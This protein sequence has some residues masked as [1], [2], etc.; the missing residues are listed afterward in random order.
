VSGVIPTFRIPSLLWDLELAALPRPAD[1]AAA[2]DL[3]WG[4]V[5]TV[6]AT[7][8][9][10]DQLTYALTFAGYELI[11]VAFHPGSLGDGAY[12]DIVDVV[13]GRY[14]VSTEGW[15][16]A[17][18][19]PLPTGGDAAVVFD[20][21]PRQRYEGAG[22]LFAEPLAAL[23]AGVPSTSLGSGWS[24]SSS[25]IHDTNILEKLQLTVRP[26]AGAT[27]D[28]LLDHIE[29]AG[30]T[31]TALV[32]TALGSIP[33]WQSRPP[34]DP[35]GLLQIF[36][37]PEWVYSVP[38]I[39][40]A[41]RQAI[42]SAG[43]ELWKAISADDPV[44]TADVV[45]HELIVNRSLGRTLAWTRKIPWAPPLGRQLEDALGARYA[46]ARSLHRRPDPHPFTGSRRQPYGRVLMAAHMLGIVDVL[47][48][49]HLVDHE[50][51][52]DVTGR[53]ETRY[54]GYDSTD[55]L[56]MR[57]LPNAHQIECI[58][59]NH[60]GSR[61]SGYWQSRHHDVASG[62]TPVT[63]W[64]FIAT[65]TGN[66]ASRTYEFQRWVDGQAG[67]PETG[68]FV[69]STAADA[70][71]DLTVEV[72][73]PQPPF[74][75]VTDY[76]RV[77]AAPHPSDAALSTLDDDEEFATVRALERFPAHHIEELIVADATTRL[78]DDVKGFLALSQGSMK[79]TRAREANQRFEE[80]IGRFLV[81]TPFDAPLVPLRRMALRELMAE[82]HN[83]GNETRTMFDW[84][85][86]MVFQELAETAAIQRFLGLLVLDDSLVQQQPMRYEWAVSLRG[87]SCDGWA[88]AGGFAGTFDITKRESPTGPV[89]WTQQYIV[90]AGTYSFGLSWGC[91]FRFE[92]SGLLDSFSDWSQET[93]EGG[94]MIDGVSSGAAFPHEDEE[95]DADGD[96]EPDTSFEGWTYGPAM[97]TFKGSHVFQ[98]L[99][100]DAS[101]WTKIEGLYFGA[102]A[103]TL[104]GRLMRSSAEP[105]QL[106]PTPEDLAALLA[107]RVVAESDEPFVQLFGVNSSTIRTEALPALELTC[108]DHLA[109]FATPWS[110]LRIVGHASTT[111]DD[112][113]MPLSRARALAVYTKIA[114]T[115]GPNLRIHE[116]ATDIGGQGEFEARHS[117]P[118]N[119]EVPG[120]RRV[121][122][123]L[124]GE[125]MIG[126]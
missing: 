25:A 6:S 76:E 111:G 29:T 57:H 114:E 75:P 73:G 47:G 97:I 63:Q 12:L 74:P 34:S 118:D 50:N 3:L 33:A 24:F 28:D 49:E 11:G 108:A 82:Q 70:D 85:T 7:L 86:D 92:T 81:D 5:S 79:R 9:A 119:T 106:Y 109:A 123:Q 115:L 40:D 43:A 61:L 30:S 102:E 121:D 104:Q 42:D 126:F 4:D 48:S 38:W 41:D 37:Q 83:A 95:H 91:N 60:A 120:W 68:R 117:I 101:G 69:F 105:T 53:Y 36:A 64:R 16:D 51:F 21:E 103:S 23:A 99:Q 71:F 88:G 35:P 17:T 84:T 55:S 15:S 72:D 125:Q 52:P 94:F 19:F 14:A 67:T 110:T 65:R 56:Q 90:V 96:G 107:K 2:L 44:V 87:A 116:E 27:Y 112:V 122:V 20:L 59:V 32:A 80:S 45:Q 100:G 66:A 89:L 18:A 77:V 31:L 113:N 1:D 26:A 8:L 10:L 98:P 22:A 58:Q 124:D 78:A 62:L 54:P 13:D 46:L 93:F 39:D